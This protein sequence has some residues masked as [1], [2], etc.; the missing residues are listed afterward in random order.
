[1]SNTTFFGFAIADS[2]FT[3]DCTIK[4]QSLTLDDVKAQIGD[5]GHQKFA[6]E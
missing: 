3:A 5:V 6:A 4:R 1:M 2:M